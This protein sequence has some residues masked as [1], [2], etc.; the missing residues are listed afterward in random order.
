MQPLQWNPDWDA[1]DCRQSAC[2]PSGVPVGVVS[3]I[4]GD[5]IRV[6][7]YAE[8]ARL[9]LLRIVDFG[10]SGVLPQSAVPAPRATRGPS[11]AA[12]R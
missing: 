12:A 3:S 2:G 11:G 7:P 6:E 1:P 4:A 8:L 10:L 5:V 9:E